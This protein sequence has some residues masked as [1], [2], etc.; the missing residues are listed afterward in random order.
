[1][2]LQYFFVWHF[3]LIRDMFCILFE[4]RPVTLEARNDHQINSLYKHHTNVY[5]EFVSLYRHPDIF[6]RKKKKNWFRDSDSTIQIVLQSCSI[7]TNH[8]SLRC[9]KSLINKLIF[10]LWMWKTSYDWPTWNN[11]IILEFHF[12]FELG[13][14]VHCFFHLPI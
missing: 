10:W 9:F 12:F 1:M 4:K 7:V 13:F 2:L 8:I 6:L 11:S 14:L 5:G 3:S